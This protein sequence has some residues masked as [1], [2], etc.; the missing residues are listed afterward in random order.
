[1]EVRNSYHLY[2]NQ[3]TL[4]YFKQETLRVRWHKI[5]RVLRDFGVFFLNSRYYHVGWN[6]LIINGETNKKVSSM[7]PICCALF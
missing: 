7:N 5:Q 6:I 4:R 1:M 2:V 3:G